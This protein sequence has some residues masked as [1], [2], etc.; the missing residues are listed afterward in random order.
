[1]VSAT[2]ACYLLPPIPKRNGGWVAIGALER[3]KT[4][5]QPR[6]LCPPLAA[7]GATGERQ[8]EVFDRAPPGDDANAV[9]EHVLDTRRILMRLRLRRP[10]LDCRRINHH[11]IGKSLGPDDAA[12]DQA[13]S[14]GGTSRKLV[15]RFFQ[16]KELPVP[17]AWP[18]EPCRRAVHAGMDDSLFEK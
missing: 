1:S 6:D 10:V 8:R 13:E 16:R 15:D 2:R 9:H 17:H 3:G 11:E 5:T 18:Q 7:Q 4:S 14:R 12:V